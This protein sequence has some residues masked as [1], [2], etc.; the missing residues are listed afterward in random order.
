MEENNLFSK[1]IDAVEIFSNS[2]LLLETNTQIQFNTPQLLINFIPFDQ[3]IKNIVFENTITTTLNRDSANIEEN[4]NSARD[5]TE[6]YNNNATLTVDNVYCSNISANGSKV[7]ISAGTYKYHCVTLSTSNNLILRNTSD[8]NN[9]EY[10]SSQISSLS[11]YIYHVL[12]NTTFTVDDLTANTNTLATA[13]DISSFGTYFTNKIIASNVYT[14]NV[15]DSSGN[16]SILGI[17]SDSAVNLHIYQDAGVSFDDPNTLRNIAENIILSDDSTSSNLKD[18]IYSFLDETVVY[19]LEMS[20]RGN[21]G[22]DITLD[23]ITFTRR[24]TGTPPF[25]TDPFEYNIV[26]RIYEYDASETTTQPGPNVV[27]PSSPNT[28]PTLDGVIPINDPLIIPD[29]STDLSTETP[30]TFTGLTAGTFYSI[31]AD[32]TNNVTKITVNNI[33]VDYNIPTIMPQTIKS[34]ILTRDNEIQIIFTRHPMAQIITGLTTTFSIKEDS[35]STGFISTGFSQNFETFT[36]A[37]YTYVFD[38]SSLSRDFFGNID[39]VSRELIPTSYTFTL[40]NGLGME[41]EGSINITLGSITTTIDGTQT[42]QT[43]LIR[44]PTKPG[45]PNMVYSSGTGTLSWAASGT[46]GSSV[47][48]TYIN[49]EIYF[50]NAIRTTTTDAS[51]TTSINVGTYYI[52]AKNYY[53]QYSVDSDPYTIYPPSIR[54]TSTNLIYNNVARQYKVEHTISGI[55]G[56]ASISGFITDGGTH[57]SST[58]SFTLFTFPNATTSGTKTCDITVTDSLNL[59]HSDRTDFLLTVTFYSAPTINLDIGTGRCEIVLPSPT[60]N[61]SAYTY[62]WSPAAAIDGVTNTKVVTILPGTVTFSCTITEKNSEGFEKSHHPALTVSTTLPTL[63][64][65]NAVTTKTYNSLLIEWTSLG[66][67]GTPSQSIDTLR[68]YYKKGSAPDTS[69]DDY[70]DITPIVPSG[71]KLI[72]NLDYGSTYHYKLVKEYSFY[73]KIFDYGNSE[74]I[75]LIFPGNPDDIS[76]ENVTYE[77][78]DVHWA[79]SGFMGNPNYYPGTTNVIATHKYIYY[80][81]SA[82]SIEDAVDGNIEDYLRNIPKYKFYRPNDYMTINESGTFYVRF[83]KRYDEYGYGYFESNMVTVITPSAPNGIQ[84]YRFQFPCNNRIFFLWKDPIYTHDTIKSMRLYYNTSQITGNNYISNNS[85]LYKELYTF[86]QENGNERR[87]Q[88]LGIK[89]YRTYNNYLTNNSVSYLS[90]YHQYKHLDDYYG[91]HHDN[92]IEIDNL[93]PD[94][95]YYFKVIIEWNTIGFTYTDIDKLFYSASGDVIFDRYLGYI[96]GSDYY[97]ATITEDSVPTTVKI[98]TIQSFRIE[99]TNDQYHFTDINISN[100]NVKDY[101]YSEVYLYIIFS[102]VESDMDSI[103]AAQMHSAIYYYYYQNETESSDTFNGY[104]KIGYYMRQTKPLYI[105]NIRFNHHGTFESNQRFF[106]NL[107]EYVGESSIY[108]KLVLDYPIISVHR[109]RFYR[110]GPNHG[111]LI[112]PVIISPDSIEWNLSTSGGILEYTS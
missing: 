79:G 21:P 26:F 65:L 97:S 28:E 68:I 14:S 103:T 51:K 16:E 89:I 4:G 99:P 83:I 59:S 25:T 35:D 10:N 2:N 5:L 71:S 107:S 48:L 62:S 81:R 63:P 24:I 101:T 36:P 27:I 29:L 3:F 52:K 56:T 41:K 8:H 93:L 44:A 1:T 57:T 73:D 60:T 47:Q 15:G 34:I 91:Y 55:N 82:F 90:T 87:V 100:E 46:Q 6:A 17:S 75:N 20:G 88:F 23:N 11:N 66:D 61:S 72:P 85:L 42:P 105:T 69:R 94:T 76:V 70:V 108:L 106:R 18:Y 39:S 111:P 19:Q 12:N 95:R 102:T 43:N 49:Y 110:T 77:S 30:K 86:Y 32:I 109:D 45:T 74:T 40:R 7:D 13:R 37:E 58:N 33:G 98:P 80:S 22:V 112:Y 104:T 84:E 54:I 9:I 92:V 64:V 53:N 78:F 31:Y 50:N 67:N 38:V 96:I